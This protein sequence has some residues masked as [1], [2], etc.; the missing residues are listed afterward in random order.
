MSQ[1]LLANGFKWKENIDKF[2]EDFIR[3][4]DV[5]GNKGYVLEDDVEYP[6]IFLVFTV[7]FH[8]QV[9][10]KKIKNVISLFLIYMTKKL[11]CSHKS[12]KTSI[13]S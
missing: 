11:C 8:F 1:K 7:I 5:D 3:N 2:D 4:Y 13:K 10:E 6:K 9:K 12:F